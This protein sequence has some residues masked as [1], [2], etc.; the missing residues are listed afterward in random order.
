LGQ[1]LQGWQD[2][3]DFIYGLGRFEGIWED[4]IRMDV[5]EI[6]ETIIGCAFRVH[7]ELG[8][9]FLEKVYENA[10]TFELAELG[11]QVK[12]QEPI[13]VYYRQKIV[14]EYYA[15]LLVEDRILVELKAVKS[16][17][18]E[19]EMQLVNYLAA[20]GKEDGLLIN[21]GSSVQVKRKYRQY[22]SG[23]SS[24][25]NEQKTHE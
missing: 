25:T 11:L 1:D 10:L 3:Q 6:T 17:V 12:Q 23:K 5:A 16:I 8:S 18:M 14:G 13:P 9:G 21:F 7:N 22:K 15:D 20:T 2:S 24:S 4:S 19:H